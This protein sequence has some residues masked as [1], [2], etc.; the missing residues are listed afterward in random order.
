MISIKDRLAAD[1]GLAGCGSNGQN[2]PDGGR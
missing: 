1:L 2:G